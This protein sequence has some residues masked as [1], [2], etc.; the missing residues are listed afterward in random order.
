MQAEAG[1][2]RVGGLG[3]GLAIV[4]DLVALHGGTIAASSEG[5]GRGATFTV[6]FPIRAAVRP[7]TPL[8]LAPRAL[9][10]VRLVVV[11]DEE[12]AR[13]IVTTILVQAGAEVFTAA[14]ADEALA[15]VI[16]ERPAAIVSDIGMPNKDGMDF[17]HDVRSL[18]EEQGGR[19]PAVALT[20]LV[21]AQDRV[22]ILAAGFNA[23]AS[24][25]VEPSELVFVVAGLLGLKVAEAEG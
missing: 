5:V 16:R 22:R 17:L 9:A 21:R 7:E 12:E 6:L 4:K 1:A 23:H 15:A 8:P 3:L 11:D 25:P 2:R 18:P 14:S 13:K 10:G 19:T 20:A 24:K